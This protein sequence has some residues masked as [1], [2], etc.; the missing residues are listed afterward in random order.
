MQ[1]HECGGLRLGRRLSDQSMEQSHALERQRDV[2]VID[3][4]DRTMQHRPGDIVVDV[5][6]QSVQFVARGH[7]Q[8]K[9]HEEC[10]RRRRQG[11]LD[12]WHDG[13][14]RAACLN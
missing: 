11:A 8:A 1:V 3:R 2:V 10:Q 12:G 13:V 9:T 6:D 4:V 5:I 7:Q 14:L